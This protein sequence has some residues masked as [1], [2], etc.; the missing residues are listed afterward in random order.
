MSK[1][2]PSHTVSRCPKCRALLIVR[3]DQFGR[4]IRCAKCAHSFIVQQPSQPTIVQN[5]PEPEEAKEDNQPVAANM[6]RAKMANKFEMN[7]GL[8]FR[9]VLQAIRSFN[10]DLKEVNH[11]MMSAKFLL[12][13]TTSETEHQLHV[14]YLSRKQSEIEIS[15]IEPAP[16]NTFERF[17]EALIREIDKYLLFARD[18][19]RLPKQPKQIEDAGSETGGSASMAVAGFVCSVLGFMTSCLTLIGI[20]LGILGLIFSILGK[21]SRYDKLALA[22]IIVGSLAVVLSI[23]FILYF[24]DRSLSRHNYYTY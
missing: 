7:S 12:V 11:T 23:I 6:A 8:V 5:A 10:C 22:G 1:S 24:M 14:F 15:S 16:F 4:K 20:S 2:N 17:Y 9:A 18:E 3:S 21:K 13:S 19:E